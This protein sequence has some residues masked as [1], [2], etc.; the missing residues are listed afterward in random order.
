[1]G[2]GPDGHTHAGASWRHVLDVPVHDGHVHRSGRAPRVDAASHAR[3]VAHLPAVSRR[4]REP[5]GALLLLHVSGCP[6]V[7]R[8]AGRDVVHGQELAGEFRRGRGI[9]LVVDGPDHDDGTGRVRLAPLHQG[10]LRADG[11]LVRLRGGPRNAPARSDDAGLHHR[12]LRHRT[13]GRALRRR[14]LPRLRTRGR[15]PRIRGSHPVC[16]ASLRADGD[17]AERGDLHLGDQRVRA[18]PDPARDRVGPVAAVRAPGAQADAPPLPVQRRQ[19]RSR[20]QVHVHAAGVRLGL[21]PGWAAPTDSAADVE[22]AVGR[23]RPGA[24]RA[25]C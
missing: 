25:T 4:H 19:E 20:L 16:G 8:R 3:S 10:V 14:P 15:C 12:G 2:C 1:M 24:R 9:P 18:S 11:S 7:P 6:D 22:L 5:L 21:V 17:D 23:R 13:A